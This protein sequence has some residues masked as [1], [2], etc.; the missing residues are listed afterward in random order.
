MKSLDQILKRARAELRINPSIEVY[1]FENGQ[2]VNRRPANPWAKLNALL[3]AKLNALLHEGKAAFKELGEAATAA[4][5]A[6]RDFN[7]WFD[8]ETQRRRW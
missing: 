1:D 8:D 3:H 7:A 4:G 6:A 2:E 5:M